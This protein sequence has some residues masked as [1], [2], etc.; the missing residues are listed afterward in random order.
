MYK[1]IITSLNKGKNLKADQVS[2]FLNESEQEKLNLA[3]QAAVLTALNIKGVSATELAYFA[4]HLQAKM[5]EL[6]HFPE[7][8]DICGTGGSGL[9]RIN[10]STISAFIISALAV[11]VAK[12]GNKAASG[13]FGSFDL[14]ETLGVKI[15]LG[16]NELDK[17]ADNLN[18]ALI[19][20]R[21]FH[22]VMKHFA[23]VRTE[24]AFPT[25]F[26]LIGPLI[27]PA[28]TKNQIIGTAFLDQMKL[29]AKTA[30]K[31]GKKNVLVVSG[32]DGLDEVTL[33]G[34]TFVTE[35]KNK[36]IRSYTLT[37]KSFGVSKCSF[38]NIKGGSAKS[39][40]QIA[41]EI[42]Q[43]KCKTRHLD[44]VL[45]N[46]ALALKLAGKVKSLKKGYQLAREVVDSGTA[47]QQFLQYKQA[48]QAPSILLEI[49]SHKK[50]ELAKRQAKMP[51]SKLKKQVK[52]SDRD[53]RTALLRKDISLIA[54]IKK[55]SPSAGVL[56]KG[57][58]NVSK[59]ANLYEAS[60]TQ[61]IS[62]IT[63]KSFFHGELEYLS[64]ARA[65]TV[66]TPLLCKDFIIDEYQIFEAR[67][68]GADAV[69]LI[70]AI[71]SKE[72]I[73]KFIKTAKSL[74]MDCLVEVHTEEELKMVLDTDAEIIGINNRDLNNFKV[75]IKTTD[76]LCKKIP[77]NKIVVS[78]S[79]ISSKAALRKLP[80]KVDAVLVGSALMKEKYPQNKIKSIFGSRKPLLKICGVQSSKEALH[81]QKLGVDFI[82]LNFVPASQRRV[83]YQLAA[84]IIKEVRK[85]KKNALKV[86][87]VF[88]D[89]EVSEINK[90]AEHLD[91][92][93]VQ[94][95][96]AEPLSLLKKINK[97]V[98]KGISIKRKSDL[99]KAKKYYPRVAHVLL[100]SKLPGSG[101]SFDH[102]LLK[103]FDLPYFLAGGINQD[104]LAETINTYQPY[105]VDI[106]SGAET[107]GKRDLKKISKLVA[108]TKR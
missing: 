68:Y 70:A 87:G 33:T 107:A 106:A 56:R 45:I 61:G 42:L 23:K 29:I 84:Q 103:N 54:E 96:G 92:D 80:Q 53:F 47:Y 58:F 13:R 55:A 101:Q 104:N 83:S 57:L 40:T 93:Y 27:N 76:H 21:K 100:D 67:K 77:R 30:K 44:L 90:A 37:P 71:L 18:L 48:S 78:E 34:K 81:C 5:P 7:A 35:L 6:I 51:L 69:L 64:K 91:L 62:V 94:L 95:S 73:E 89:H 52:L 4:K 9:S 2:F 66:H 8:I 41:L 32:E 26:N 86:I 19:F 14:L 50:K 79:G 39:N 31:I 74:I 49:V 43:G 28:G 99:N 12:H 46:S 97:D 11:P 16:K 98:I 36:N 105:V 38:E 10:T 82:G 63:D 25:I 22:P 75:N 59:I 60:N 15:D 3:Q 88:Q 108:I 102:L 17:I 1:D 20:A 72:E 65:A 85:Q 24:L